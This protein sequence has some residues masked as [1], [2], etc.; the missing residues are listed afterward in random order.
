MYN[1]SIKMRKIDRNLVEKVIKEGLIDVD[2]SKKLN[3]NIETFRRIR[4][5]LGYKSNK[6]YPELTSFQKEVL[7]GTILAD[8]SLRKIGNR[9][10]RGKLEHCGKQLNYL[11]F[12]KNILDCITSKI[13]VK[14]RLLKKTNKFYTTCYCTLDA[15][16][17]LDYL[18]NQFYPNG[19]KVIPID[20]LYKEFTNVSLAIAFQ[21]DGNKTKDK[22]YEFNF[23]CF[24]QENLQEFKDFLYNKFKL[25]AT[26]RPCGKVYIKRNS[27]ELFEFLIKEYFSESTKYKLLTHAVSQ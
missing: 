15:H 17:Y 25:D 24:T 19:K 22:S 13:T 1:Y 10:A 26:F 7:I 16:P 20:L 27:S 9:V 4:R 14:D 11:E 12:K 3:I 2:A 21:D 6:I 8:G 5:E 18:Y 23:M